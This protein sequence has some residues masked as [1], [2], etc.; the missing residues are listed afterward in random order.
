MNNSVVYIGH[1]TDKDGSHPTEEKVKTI[2]DAPI[3]RGVAEL[4][5]YLGMLIYYSKFVLDRATE[6]ALLHALL[7]KGA[8]WK[9][10]RIKTR[11]SRN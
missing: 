10:L 3:P 8:T 4:K 2:Q 5:A 1:R 7:Q 9:W 6:L 11:P